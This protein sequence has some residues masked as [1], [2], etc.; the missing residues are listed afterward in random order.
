MKFRFILAAS[1]IL[2]VV[3]CS[4]LTQAER[5]AL[6]AKR[7]KYVNSVLNKRRY[8][9]DVTMMYPRRG[10]AEVLTSNWSVEVKGDTL[11]SYLPYFGV[12]HEASFGSNPGLNFTAPIKSYQDSGFKKGKRLIQL[13]TDSEDDNLQYQFEIMDNG[14]TSIEVISRKK[15]GIGYSGRITE[16]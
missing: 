11:V 4:T 16:E 5:E 2:G 1:L 15:D 13:K 3:S 6:N 8:T 10:G 7:T 9:I 12:A 14:S